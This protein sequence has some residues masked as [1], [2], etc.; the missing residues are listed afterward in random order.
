VP[1]HPQGG[2]N[3]GDIDLI[4]LGG[5]YHATYDAHIG[6]ICEK[7]FAHL[8]AGLLICSAS[9]TAGT[10]AFIQDQQVVRVK[11]ADD[12]RVKGSL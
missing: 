9:A 3:A 4:C 5:H 10:T 8:R 6:I 1:L 2:A 12:R 7:A 11:H